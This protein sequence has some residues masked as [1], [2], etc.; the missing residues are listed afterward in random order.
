[1]K[2]L[3]LHTKHKIEEM[4]LAQITDYNHEICETAGLPVTKRFSTK[5]KAIA[6]TLSNQKIYS[7]KLAEQKKEPAKKVAS[8]KK[9]TS[10]NSKRVDRD[11][12]VSWIGDKPNEGTTEHYIYQALDNMFD[13][14]GEIISYVILKYTRP[15]GK[16][17]TEG[18]V[19]RRMRKALNKGLIEYK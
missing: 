10:T 5:P 12:K 11:T 1:M 9:E 2:T 3:N 4:T 7:A 14:I 16:E 15:S 18:L 19:L 17:M 8:K 13:T 6:K